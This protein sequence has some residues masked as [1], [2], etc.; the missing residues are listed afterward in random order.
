MLRFIKLTSRIINTTN[1]SSINL[2]NEKVPK[3]IIIN[4]TQSDFSGYMIYGTGHFWTKSTT[5]VKNEQTEPKYYL[6][7][8]KWI[9]ELDN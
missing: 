5:I 4:L 3:Y 9:N 8:N 6:I 2:Y 7:M 1:I